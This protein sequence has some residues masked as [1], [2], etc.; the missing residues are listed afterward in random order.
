[1]LQDCLEQIKE[2]KDSFGGLSLG[3]G[4]LPVFSLATTFEAVAHKLK[5]FVCFQSGAWF[6]RQIKDPASRLHQKKNSFKVT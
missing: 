5:S 3:S 2:G 4:Q 6:V 1:M